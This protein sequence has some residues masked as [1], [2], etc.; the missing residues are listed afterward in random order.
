MHITRTCPHKANV[1]TYV[2]YHL[3]RQTTEGYKDDVDPET[4]D[5]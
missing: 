3:P 1:T 5:D 2:Q 4:L